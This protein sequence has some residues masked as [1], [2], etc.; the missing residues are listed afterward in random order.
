MRPLLSF[1]ALA[2]VLIIKQPDLGTAIVLGCITFAMLFAAGVRL[3]LSR[4]R[5]PRSSPSASVLA[6]SAT[7]RRIAC[8]RS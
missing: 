4:P 1:M 5:A 8:C 2:A 7:Y 3:P 6:L